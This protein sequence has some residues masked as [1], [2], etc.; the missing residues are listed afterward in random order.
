MAIDP[1]NKKVGD[2]DV[3][4]PLDNPAIAEAL[5]RG[6][7]HDV[8][9]LLT[10][11]GLTIADFEQFAANQYAK[12]MTSVVQPEPLYEGEATAPPPDYEAFPVQ[13]MSNAMTE[14]DTKYAN[15]V[16][17]KAM[18]IGKAEGGGSA[19]P[20]MADMQRHY[21]EAVT[22]VNDIL[23]PRAIEAQLN[24]ELNQMDAKI[25]RELR[26]AIASIKASG[27]DA[28]LL[29]L[30]LVKANVQRNGL[31]FTQLGQR[32]MKLNDQMNEAYEQLK[33]NPTI[34]QMYGAQQDLKSGTQGLQFLINDMNQ[35]TQH[36]QSTLTFGKSSVDTVNASKLEI[37]RKISGQ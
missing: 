37:I 31:I 3:K 13:D 16:L 28:S 17:G 26:E 4:L 8:H 25:Q 19:A 27:G 32:V 24:M 12:Y 22:F 34:Q 36:V 1:I 35:V 2:S 20:G 14:D 6:N 5:R 10:D 18:G 21:D 15:E 30:A 9:K 11:Y 33:G 7:I 29:I 23:E